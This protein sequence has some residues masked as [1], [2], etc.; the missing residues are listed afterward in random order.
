MPGVQST[1]P[2]YRTALFNDYGNFL[3]SLRGC[4]VGAEDSGW[5]AGAS[6]M[7][8]L[9]IALTGRCT[10]VSMDDIDVVFSKTRYTTCISP[11]KGGSGNPSVPT[12][13]GVVSAIEVRACCPAPCV[14]R[15]AP[16]R[17]LLH[18]AC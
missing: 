5:L 13:A 11:H 14:R 9:R 3:T 4:Y 7:C 17:G 2:R 1:E 8:G 16:H 18:M 6:R 10:G 12:A 15:S